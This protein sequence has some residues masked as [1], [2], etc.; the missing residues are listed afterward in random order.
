MLITRIIKGLHRFYIYKTGGDSMIRYMRKKGAKIGMS[1]R[2]HTMSFITEPYLVEIGDYVSIADGTVFITHDGG[3][4]C[5]RDEFPDDDVFGKIIIGNNVH[6]GVNCT[7]LLN[8]TIGNNCII[9]AGSVVR[10]RFPENSVIIGNPA[11][12]V[13]SMNA[14][15]LLY[16]QNPG[17]L[18]TRNM[19]DEEKKPMVLQ[20][21]NSEK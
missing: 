15:K 20:H 14:Q 7:I 1:C 6:I 12:A 21:F 3:I 8:T 18:N 11:K 13:M 2:L 4:T 17:R 16:K 5:F 19:T 10:G 9:G